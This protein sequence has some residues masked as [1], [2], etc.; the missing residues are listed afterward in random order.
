MK[1]IIAVLIL[2][3]LITLALISLAK[4]IIVRRWLEDAF[5]RNLSLQVRMQELYVGIFSPRL[6]IEGLYVLNPPRFGRHGM[7][8]APQAV[9]DYDFTDLLKRHFRVKRMTLDILEVNM[10]RS[11]DGELN[12]N[13][14]RRAPGRKGLVT[15]LRI[16]HL[17]LSIR[18]V[19]Y[20]DL[21]VESPVKVYDLNLKNLEFK[22]VNSL[23]ALCHLITLKIFERIG[24][25]QFGIEEK[26]KEGAASK[27]FDPVASA[28]TFIEDVIRSLRGAIPP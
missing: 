15:D 17:D 25:N 10:V 4:E 21:G 18:R 1:K 24:L 8:H 5:Q 7:A 2:V 9:M 13:S 11:A 23:E 26:P 16:E 22:N 19:T 28:G 3:C 20:Q 6:A 12:L 27:G 14:I